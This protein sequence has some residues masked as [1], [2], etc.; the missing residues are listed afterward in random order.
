[1]DKLILNTFYDLSHVGSKGK[2]L[3]EVK[4]ILFFLR[5]NLY[6]VAHIIV[7]MR[8]SFEPGIDDDILLRGGVY[9]NRVLVI[10]DLNHIVEDGIH[11]LF[12]QILV[13]VLDVE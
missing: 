12:K 6:L 1:M 5:S 7:R 11:V 13:I 4:N 8:P 2:G 10:F 3:E 9:W